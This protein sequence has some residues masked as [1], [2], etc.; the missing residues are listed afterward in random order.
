MKRTGKIIVGLCITC[1]VLGACDNDDRKT[2]ASGRYV[3]G[4]ITV[5]RNQYNCDRYGL[6]NWDWQWAEVTTYSDGWESV[7]FY[8]DSKEVEQNWYRVP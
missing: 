4:V 3:S 2:D 5:A 1:V 7:R 6:P 8:V